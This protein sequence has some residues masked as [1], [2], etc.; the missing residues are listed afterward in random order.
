MDPWLIGM[1]CK[2]HAQITYADHT[3][4]RSVNHGGLLSSN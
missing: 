3:L 4:H 2:F 1:G